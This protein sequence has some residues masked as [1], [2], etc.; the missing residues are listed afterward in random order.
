MINPTVCTC[1][2]DYEPDPTQTSCIMK[3]YSV[4]LTPDR[5]AEPS[6][7]LGFTVKVENQNHE[8]P[9]NPVTVHLAL[10]VDDTSGGHDHGDNARP[11]G[12]IAEL[13]CDSDGECW[14]HET[15][16]TGAVV[17]NFNAPEASGTHTITATCE[18]CS[19]TATTTV[20][21]KVKGIEPIPNFPYYALVET[22][23]DVIGA[24]DLH[25][26]NH[27]LLPAAAGVLMRIAVNYH[28]HPRLRVLDWQTNRMVPPP[29]LHINDASL[30]WGGK[31]DIKGIWTGSHAEHKRG[32]S[33][34]LRAN[35]NVGAIP[36]ELFEEFD[37]WLMKN[38]LGTQKR[39]SCANAHQTKSPVHPTPTRFSTI[40]NQRIIASARLMAHSMITVIT[41][42]D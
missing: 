36:P 37:K 18:G 31:F 40:A 24:T 30:E 35:E 27:N 11:R 41:M 4:T 39:N 23:G 38:I 16:G 32:T 33:V 19:N 1:N 17:F 26:N 2:E 8:P 28:F 22:N 5:P 12:G 25:S 7:V 10:R 29:L 21:V 42:F 13:A 14:S 6:Q 9:K 34:D 15:D 20:D 3:R